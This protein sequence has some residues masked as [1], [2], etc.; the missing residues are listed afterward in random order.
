MSKWEGCPVIACKNDLCD[1][2]CQALKRQ[3]EMAD[4][5]Q[6]WGRM[7]SARR[8]REAM[9]GI[10]ASQQVTDKGEGK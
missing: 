8:K 6:F 5:L 2:E 3:K 9:L 4:A 1:L 10:A 7:E